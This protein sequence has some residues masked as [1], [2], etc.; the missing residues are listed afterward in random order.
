MK[1]FFSII[2][3]LTLIC[4]S[5]SSLSAQ[6]I[7][8]IDIEFGGGG[9]TPIPH[10]TPAVIPIAATYI[11][12]ISSVAFLFTECLGIVSI[13]ISNVDTGE[14]IAIEI[15]TDEISNQMVYIG[16]AL[17]LYTVQVSLPGGCVYYGDFEI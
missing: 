2:F 6:T 11:S 8:D 4:F 15:N 14:T 10:R 7:G 13:I 5:F 1:R 12:A 16:G 3:I 9:G 17:G